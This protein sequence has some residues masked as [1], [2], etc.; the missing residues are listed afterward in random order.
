MITP[1]KRKDFFCCKTYFRV[2]FT[3]GENN[4]VM[5]ELLH[6]LKTPGL[7]I[8]TFTQTLGIY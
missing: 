4:K 2:C 7:V 1:L 3:S 8:R 6:L 5:N